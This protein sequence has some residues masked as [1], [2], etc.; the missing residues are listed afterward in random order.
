MREDMQ[1]KPVEQDLR[2]IKHLCNYFAPHKPGWKDSQPS[3]AFFQLSVFVLDFGPGLGS[4][5]L[6][7]S[8]N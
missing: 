3:E 8:I 1:M 2:Q 7:N 6:I 4:V 5:L